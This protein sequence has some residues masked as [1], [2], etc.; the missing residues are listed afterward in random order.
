MTETGREDDRVLGG[1]DIARVADGLRFAFL[2]RGN[3]QIEAGSG[4]GTSEH[5]RCAIGGDEGLLLI[6]RRVH[7]HHGLARHE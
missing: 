4:D 6:R 2:S 3:P 5:Q 7:C 1:P